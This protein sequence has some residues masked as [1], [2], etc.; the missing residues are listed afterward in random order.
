MVLMKEESEYIEETRKAFDKY[1]E[2]YEDW[3]SKDEGK[4]IKKTE[5]R[6][7]ERLVPNGKGLEVGVGSGIFASNLGINYGIDPSK[8]MLNIA[9]KRGI[10]TV[11]GIAEMLPFK[12]GSF[13]FILFMFTISFLTD[14]LKAFREAHRVLKKNGE[15]I[16]CYIQK[17]SPWGEYYR[18]KKDNNH[19]SYKHAKFHTNEEIKNLIKK[20]DF[21]TT[22][23]VSTLFQKPKAVEKVEE[24]NEGSDESAGL[25][26]VKAVKN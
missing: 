10:E 6:A 21:R 16:I 15:L 5:M 11:L 24:P 13:D 3:F 26:C 20:T 8:N 19:D 23:S 22:E 1:S 12:E 7:V 18:E 25:C 9:Q 4:I 14:P 17:N 2:R